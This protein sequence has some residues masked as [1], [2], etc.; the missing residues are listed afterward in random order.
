MWLKDS[1]QC[2]ARKSFLGDLDCLCGLS[3]VIFCQ[4]LLHVGAEFS[5]KMYMY[6][7]YLG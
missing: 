4:I 6:K 1:P 3:F 5:S 7:T 2:E